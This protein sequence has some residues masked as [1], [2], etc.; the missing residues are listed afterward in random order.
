M[1]LLLFLDRLRGGERWVEWHGVFLGGGLECVVSLTIPGKMR[2]VLSEEFSPGCRMTAWMS[3]GKS[4]N[5]VSRLFCHLQDQRLL[6]RSSTACDAASPTTP[7]PTA[8][9]PH[10]PAYMRLQSVYASSLASPR[11]PLRYHPDRMHVR[12]QNWAGYALLEG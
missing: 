5:R 7:S 12:A 8:S 2:P 4:A 9:T 10:T 3:S 6:P 1:F 11:S